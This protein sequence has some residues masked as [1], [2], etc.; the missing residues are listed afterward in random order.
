MTLSDRDIPDPPTDP[1]QAIADEFLERFRR[2]ERPSLTDY[3]GRHPDL[4]DRIDEVL[5]ALIELEQF[6]TVDHPLAA[7]GPARRSSKRSGAVRRLP[8]APRG[9]PRWDGRRL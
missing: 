7:P 1:L 8:A 2:G 9:R 6:G 3:K 5:P 4:A